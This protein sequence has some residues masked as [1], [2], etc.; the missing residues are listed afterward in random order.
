V[1]LLATCHLDEKEVWVQSSLGERVLESMGETQKPIA[2]DWSR[3]NKL[4]CLAESMIHRRVLNSRRSRENDTTWLFGPLKFAD[5]SRSSKPHPTPGLKSKE[6]PVMVVRSILKRR[7]LCDVMLQRSHHSMASLLKG[8]PI[9]RQLEGMRHVASE[10]PKCLG[11]NQSC[12]AGEPGRD[13]LLQR[14]AGK[15]VRFDTDFGKVVA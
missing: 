1:F 11:F 12:N 6:D 8:D 7:K 10:Q 13:A 5:H 14:T 9:R 4:V 15:Q 3:G 2:I